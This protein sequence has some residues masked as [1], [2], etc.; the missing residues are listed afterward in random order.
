MG[1]REAQEALPEPFFTVRLIHQVCDAR[2]AD[3]VPEPQR[4]LA[5]P[6]AGIPADQI[7]VSAFPNG[8]PGGIGFELG[9]AFPQKTHKAT[10]ELL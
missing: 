3:A 1:F 5:A 10:T 4:R 9:E 8:F 6:R 7:P 2:K